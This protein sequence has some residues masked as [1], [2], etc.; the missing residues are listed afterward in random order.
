[1]SLL[2]LLLSEVP[3]RANIVVNPGFD[4]GTAVAQG[5]PI[6]NWTGHT[7]SGSFGFGVSNATPHSAPYAAV[8]S[9]MGEAC[10]DAVN[11]TYISQALPT[12]SA[13]SYTVTF[14]YNSRVQGSGASTGT[15][16]TGLDV[17]WDGALV[18]SLPNAAPGYTQHTINGLVAA[19]ASTVLQFNG[20]NDLL[21]GVLDDIDAVS[22]S[23]VPE[24]STHLLGALGL[25]L[26]GLLRRWR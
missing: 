7:T 19:G 23:D 24:P 10:L 20:R 5:Q 9:C 18:L 13:Q 26:V 2:A 16:Y 22:D 12:V 3:G 15:S 25:A 14:W 8:T 17:Y 21:M 4:L 11:G 1:M 6:Q